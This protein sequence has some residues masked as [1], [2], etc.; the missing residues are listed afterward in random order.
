MCTHLTKGGE[1]LER[2]K[3]HKKTTIK[4]KE[5]RILKVTLGNNGEGYF[6]P[7]I[8]LP[9]TWLDFLG[10]TENEREIKATLNPRTKKIIIVKC[11]DNEVVEDEG[12]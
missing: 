2:K 12:E 1:K 7:K 10:I 6:A 8:S 5:T 4:S 3:R 11:Q 9:K